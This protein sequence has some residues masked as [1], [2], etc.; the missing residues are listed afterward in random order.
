MDAGGADPYRAMIDHFQAV[1]RGGAKLRRSPADSV[2]LLS[3]L[4]RLREAARL[5]PVPAGPAL[6]T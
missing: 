5:G 3:V 6:V 2:A 4:D 1:V